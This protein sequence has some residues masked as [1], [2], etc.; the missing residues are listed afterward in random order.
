MDI[1]GLN[2]ELNKLTGYCIK[3]LICE[4]DIISD[5]MVLTIQTDQGLGINL[6]LD[7]TSFTG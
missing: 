5:K 4:Y 6:I 2:K 7:K 1:Q 3:H